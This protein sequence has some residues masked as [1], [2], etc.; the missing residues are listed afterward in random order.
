MMEGNRGDALENHRLSPSRSEKKRV[1]DMPVS[2]LRNFA[3]S[4]RNIE[5]GKHRPGGFH[6]VFQEEN[7]L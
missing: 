4:E 3:V 6:K 1:I 7:L 5:Q 2:M